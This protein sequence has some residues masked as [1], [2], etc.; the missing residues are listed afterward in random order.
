M[1]TPSAL[2][3]STEERLQF[4]RNTKLAI[5]PPLDDGYEETVAVVARDVGVARDAISG[6][7]LGMAGHDTAV[8]VD[9]A[10][11]S[12]LGN[13]PE[14]H[15]SAVANT[16]LFAQWSSNEQ[17]NRM[18]DTME[19]YRAY[20]ATLNHLGWQIQNFTELSVLNVNQFGSVDQ[21]VIAQLDPYLGSRA[22]LFKDMIN[23]LKATDND[24][25]Y[26]LFKSQSWQGTMSDFHVGTC[27]AL[28][29]GRISYRIGCFKYD[30]QDFAGD[31][32]FSKFGTSTVTL[33]YSTQ[34]MILDIGTYGPLSDGVEWQLGN[35]AANFV[36]SIHL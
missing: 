19:W 14:W 20:A 31:V 22:V 2:H 29:D 28:S 25:A 18:T 7:Q 6:L 23:A 34:D 33:T 30:F 1:S 21:A 36:R 9:S 12:F 26:N 13:I 15:R 5:P 27:E 10:A 35:R 3:L 4:I 11:T 17:F 32:L 8:V 16:S 24:G